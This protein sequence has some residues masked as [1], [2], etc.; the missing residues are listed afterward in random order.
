MAGEL[1]FDH[2]EY[3]IYSPPSR[4][5]PV[6]VGLG[7]RD[8]PSSPVAEDLSSGGVE[9]GDGFDDVT[10]ALIEERHQ[11][12]QY[13]AMPAANQADQEMEDERNAMLD[14]QTSQM[15]TQSGLVNTGP[16]PAQYDYRGLVEDGGNPQPEG[17]QGVALPNKHWN[18]MTYGIAG[19]DVVTGERVTNR[20]HDDEGFI[21]AGVAGIRN[22]TSNPE[23]GPPIEDIEALSHIA[24]GLQQEGAGIEEYKKQ[25]GDYHSDDNIQRAWNATM[26]VRQR[27]ALE[28]FAV[29]YGEEAADAIGEGEIPVVEEALHY[30][31]LTSHEQWMQA[32]RI[33]WTQ[34]ESQNPEE[35]PIT[36]GLEGETMAEPGP[37][38]AMPTDEELSD[39]LIGTMSNF[40]W[41]VSYMAY[42]T[43]RVMNGD[44]TFAQA[45]FNAMQL[46][47]ALESSPGEAGRAVGSLLADPLTYASFGAGTFAAKAAA[48]PLKSVVAR[49]ALG[50]AAGG[51]FEGGLFMGIDD[52]MRQTVAMEAGQQEE[53]D[54]GQTAKA[55]GMG[56]AGGAVLGAPL[57]AAGSRP[58][59]E[60][61][62]RAGRRVAENARSVRH[63]A[64]G[65]P[66][67]QTGSIGDQAAGRAQQRAQ[68]AREKLVRGEK[69]NDLDVLA[70]LENAQ[71]EVQSPLAYH[72]TLDHVRKTLNRKA[73]VGE[74]KFAQRVLCDDEGC[75]ELGLP[76]TDH[77]LARV[78]EMLSPEEMA[79]AA[80][81]YSEIAEAFNAEFGDEGSRVMIAW[82]MSNQNVDP[83]GALMNALRVREQV[84]SGATGKLG[85][86]SDAMVRKLFQGEVPSKGMGLKLHDFIDSAL[87]KSK[88]TTWGDVVEGG[89]PAVIDVHSARDMGYVDPAYRNYLVER[90]GKDA[91]EA[92]GIPTERGATMDF[93]KEYLDQETGKWVMS[94]GPSDTQ[95][96]RAAKHMRALTDELNERGFMGGEL[97]PAQ[98]QAIGWTAQARRTGSEAFNA[99]QSIHRNTRQL[100]YELAPGT[101]TEFAQRFGERFD[102]LDYAEKARVTRKVTDLA[103][104]VALSIVRPHESLRFHGPGGWMDYPAMPSAHAKVVAT[105]EAAEDMAAIMGYLLQQDS[106]LVSR[107]VARKTGWKAGLDIVAPALTNPE[108]VTEFW[109]RLQDASPQLKELG[110]MPMREQGGEGIR[111]V[112]PKG[113]NKYAA[114]LQEELS[115]AVERVAE[116]M[117]LDNV[118]PAF[119]KMEADF[120]GNDWSAAPKGEGYLARIAKRYG[121]GVQRTLE[122]EHRRNIAR[123]FDEEITK[124]EARAGK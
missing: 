48:V 37:M 3:L 2:P 5:N 21:E 68:G 6:G 116:E 34:L 42:L 123:L 88:R 14:E 112:F 63:M 97:T 29:E 44:E 107:P 82:L 16:P 9:D 7:R 59:R 17:G 95:Y 66:M 83:A 101:A 75:V 72:S 99:V 32:A 115:D 39:W 110:F 62:M 80:N 70:M 104:G 31:D 119:T 64:P 89:S 96:E 58:A 24:Y 85:G 102:A 20:W 122:R 40:N 57:A 61:Y 109:K 98:V 41:N 120:H 28:E 108:K 11:Q 36:E 71:D 12:L 69:V 86:L 8:V 30:E 27:E 49:V 67:A 10:D 23:L 111:I 92:M 114:Q 54:I 117:D 74:P 91:V 46:Y 60:L 103:G 50:G 25:L 76:S 15:V 43:T 56:M 106:V 65:T 100:S 81:W 47:D 19:R 118:S 90:F 18:P 79:E 26:R 51:A 53:R 78:G 121:P 113:G 1:R 55:T 33:L 124:A 4:E 77:W 22:S 84:G 13:Q 73:G 87:G 94:G 105:K 45:A 93:G 35:V 52:T 38:P